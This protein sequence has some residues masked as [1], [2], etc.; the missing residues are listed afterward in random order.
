[1]YRPTNFKMKA[2]ESIVTE[3]WT[4]KHS[5]AHFSSLCNNSY[6]KGDAAVLQTV[7][8]WSKKGAGERLLECSG[9]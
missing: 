5:H 9:E 1:M 8:V 3:I 7:A 2:A 4:D 6:L